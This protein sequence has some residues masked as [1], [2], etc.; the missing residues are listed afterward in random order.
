MVR[1]NKAL[2]IYALQAVLAV[3]VVASG[4]AKLS[5]AWPEMLGPGRGLLGGIGALELAAGL[6][7][8]LPH[9]GIVGALLL[10]CATMGMLGA[11]VGHMASLAMHPAQHRSF[12]PVRGASPALPSFRIIQQR[13]V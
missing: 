2:A 4:V 8:L 9:G 5:S 7:L 13:D 10:A 3:V 11:S 12:A 1:S 6:Y